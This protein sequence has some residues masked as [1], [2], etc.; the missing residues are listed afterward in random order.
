[1]ATLLFALIIFFIAGGYLLDRYLDHLN[2]KNR[3]REIP[4]EMKGIYDEGKYRKSREYDKAKNKLSTWSS[5]YN[6]I[7][8]LLMLFFYGF[9]ILDN[10]I[11]TITENTVYRGLL[12]FG[13]LFFASDIINIPFSVISTFV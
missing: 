3:D 6:L 7:L 12:F 4:D 8:I 9:A 10:R 1:M 5:T 13:V 11:S 2:F